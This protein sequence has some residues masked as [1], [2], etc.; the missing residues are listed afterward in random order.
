M[1]KRVRKASQH[2]GRRYARYTKGYWRRYRKYRKL[3]FQRAIYNLKRLL[4]NRSDPYPVHPPGT[5]GRPPIPPKEVLLALMMRVLLDLSYRDTESF[6]L[7]AVGGTPFLEGV[8]AASTMQARLGDIPTRYL[9]ALLLEAVHVLEGSGLVLLVDA[10]GLSTQEYGRWRSA[11]RASRKVKRRYVK[12]HLLVDLERK[13]VL[14]GTG[15]K[16][17]KG[18]GPFGRR[19]LERVRGPLKRAGLSVDAL[20][21]DGAYASRKTAT[22][23]EALGG[24]PCLKVRADATAKSKGHPAWK[25]MVHRQREDP[26]AFLARYCY[27]VVIEGV[28]GAIKATFGRTI[29]SRKRHHQD[30]EVL[31]RLILWNC[32]R[33][34]VD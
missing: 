7:W 26:E 15:S 4:E 8:P 34:E 30:V 6:L 5:V 24:E 19:L 20:V 32:M 27:R 1:A 11:C 31:C 28:I 16:G 2:S 10:T 22:A 25:R 3:R 23:V 21:G 33:M 12:L 29:R 14:L 18:D 9:E 17:W 13:L